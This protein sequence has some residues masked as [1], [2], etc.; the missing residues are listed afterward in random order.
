M[1]TDNK[2]IRLVVLYQ[3]PLLVWHIKPVSGQCNA[4]DR[5]VVS[6]LWWQSTHRASD[7]TSA[8]FIAIASIG[9]HHSAYV[10]SAC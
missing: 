6:H 7:R 8:I 2:L 3:P 1:E 4:N 5:F 9:Y 10:V